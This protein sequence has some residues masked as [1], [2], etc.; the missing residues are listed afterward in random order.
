MKR[1]HLTR[2]QQRAFAKLLRPLLR[3]PRPTYYAEPLCRVPRPMRHTTVVAVDLEP[4]LL[5]L[6]RLHTGNT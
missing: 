2:R 3:R 5:H 4:H 6:S 1:P